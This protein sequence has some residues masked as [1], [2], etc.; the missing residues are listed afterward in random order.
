MFTGLAD[1]VHDC[2]DSDRRL[3]EQYYTLAERLKDAGYTTV[4]LFAGPYLHPV[5]G[6]NQ[7]FDTYVDCT[8][9]PQPSDEGVAAGG[10]MPSGAK[11][12]AADRD[13]TNPKVVEEV[14]RWLR[15]NTR[16][17]FFMFVHLWDVHF[18]FIPPPP[19]QTMFDADYA[20]NITG[21]RFLQDPRINE[22]MPKRDLEHLLALYDS[23]IA[24]TDEHFGKIFDEFDAAEL[25]DSTL[26]ILTADHGTAFFEHKLKGHRNSLFDEV[27]RIPLI[28]RYPERVPAGRRY[29]QQARMIDLLPTAVDLLGVPWDYRDLMGQSLAP[30]FAGG[31]LPRDDPAISELSSW[32]HELQS[33]RRL[34]RK[35]IWDLV[36]NKGA[37]FDLRADPGELAS[38]RDLEAPTV[39]AAKQDT[40]WSRGLL[41]L[42]RQRYPPSPEISGLPVDLQEKLKSLGYVG[43]E[44]LG[45]PEA[46]PAP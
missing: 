40:Q 18:D 20:G 22:D 39:K 17:P 33:V 45:E 30:L 37:I 38:L 13:I 36:T 14:Q 9:Y 27:I 41:D 3:D 44:M 25:L 15:E 34:E 12:E 6:L 29:R 23:E 5:F 16:R 24:W 28:I 1:S 43:D 4:G 26:I 10:T 35:A 21:E 31:K 32:G 8:W 7:G 19:Y 46:A 11:P 2:T 42:F